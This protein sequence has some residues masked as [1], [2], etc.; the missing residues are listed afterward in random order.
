MQDAEVAGSFHELKTP[1]PVREENLRSEALSEW[2][3]SGMVTDVRI[4]SM[5]D[6]TRLTKDG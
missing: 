3:L 4:G 6:S 5:T 1:A 2:D